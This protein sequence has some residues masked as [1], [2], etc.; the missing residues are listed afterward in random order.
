MN[1]GVTKASDSACDRRSSIYEIINTIKSMWV[2][3]HIEYANSR[4]KKKKR[5]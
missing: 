3:I 5:R 2:G 1:N 4:A